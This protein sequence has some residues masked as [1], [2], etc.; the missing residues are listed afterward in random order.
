MGRP[1][2]GV[3]ASDDVDDSAA[4]LSRRSLLESRGSNSR[5]RVSM[6][7]RQ[8]APGQSAQPRPRAASSRLAGS[9][10]S[11]SDASLSFYRESRRTEK[12]RYARS[13]ASRRSVPDGNASEHAI[14]LRWAAGRAAH[15]DAGAA[16]PMA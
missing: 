5:R 10:R 12:R 11:R 15:Q 8:A 1:S 2:D 16:Q 9:E 7:L 14:F 4:N 3:L 6:R 13:T